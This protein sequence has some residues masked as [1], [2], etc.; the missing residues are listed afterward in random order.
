MHVVGEDLQRELV[1]IE[2][3]ERP[4]RVALWLEANIG[5]RLVSYSI[6]VTRGELG[7][8]VAGEKPHPAVERRLRNMFAVCSYL[9]AADGAGHAHDWLV[10]RNPELGGRAPAEML[11]QGR[12]PERLWLAAVPAY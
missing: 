10:E 4:D 8:I 1:E 11:H 12:A 7:R 9:A 6:C 5:P 3:E 2:R